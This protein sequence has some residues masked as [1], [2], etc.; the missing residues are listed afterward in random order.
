MDDY[1]EMLVDFIKSL[2]VYFQFKTFCALFG[3]ICFFLFG[4]NIRD[5]LIPSLLLLMVLDYVL[6]FARGWVTH[7]ISSGK[8][9]RG[10]FK[11]ILY[12]IAIIVSVHINQA[13]TVL[14]PYFAGVNICPF[15]IAYLIINEALS[16]LEHLTY[17]GVP[18]PSK[19]VSRLRAYRDC[20]MNTDDIIPDPRDKKNENNSDTK[21]T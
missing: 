18:L 4:E 14:I 1:W 7:R 11:F 9:K 6:G 10:L 19:I 13:L 15:L 3:S 17:F 8:M 21:T 2:F 20:I 12:G 16:V 5:S